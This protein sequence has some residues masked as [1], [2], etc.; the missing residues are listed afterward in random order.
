[1]CG[2]T[3]IAN[4][5]PAARCDVEALRRMTETLANRGPDDQRLWTENGIG[6]GV[7]RLSVIDPAGGQQP[8]VATVGVKTAAVLAYTGE[9]YNHDELRTELRGYGHRFATRSDTEVVLRAYQQWGAD[10]GSHLE[11]MFAFAVWD[12]LKQQLVLFRDRFGIYPLYYS[13][14]GGTF[15]FASEPKALL[16]HPAVRPVVD[17]DGIREFLSLA[18][19]PGH[20]IYRD[21][22]ELKPGTVLTVDR[23]GTRVFRYWSLRAAPHVD[24]LDIT[25]SVIRDMLRETMSR[26]VIADVPLCSLLSGGLDSSAVTALAAAEMKKQG[27]DLQT[28]AVDFVGHSDNFGLDGLREAPDAPFVRDVARH[29][30]TRH[31]DVVLSAADL[32]SARAR[33]DVLRAR[34]CPSPLGD[35]FTSLLILSRE[36]RRHSTVTL[37]GDGSDEY[38]GGYHFFQEGASAPERGY[39]TFAWVEAARSYPGSDLMNPEGLL[40][41]KLCAKIDL[42]NY[43]AERYADACAEIEYLDGESPVNSRIRE[44][45]YHSLTRYLLIILDRRDRMGMASGLEARVPLLNHRLVE[46][47][48]NIP[49]EMKSFDGREKS[50]LRAAVADVLPRSVLDRQKAPYPITLDPAYDAG[51]RDELASIWRDPNAPARELFD[52]GAVA[53]VLADPA[54]RPELN[55]TALEAAVGLNRWLELYHVDLQI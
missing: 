37:T 25:I 38:F 29:V 19:T 18:R 12:A 53:D 15:L 27:R 44:I 31:M 55:R 4:F 47:V 54:R 6:L 21:I 5:G 43:E 51:L 26:E 40:D 8:V 49:W 34:D 42:E 28:F 35:L 24:D 1:M 23:T 9:V 16:A 52:A 11:G 45:T 20:G 7:R 32:M 22:T 39:S 36:V 30:G 3:G 50:L 17:I 13:S 14:A 10:C 2:I 33:D 41:R 48:Y 46:Y